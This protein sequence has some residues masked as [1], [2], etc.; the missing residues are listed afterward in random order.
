MEQPMKNCFVWISAVIASASACAFAAAPQQGYPNRPVRV[1]VFVPAGGG[2]DLLARITGLKLGEALGQTIVVDNRAGMGGVIATSLVAKA[3]PDGY[4][5]LQ[6]GI[7]THGIGPHIYGNLPYDP[8]K[9]FAPIVLTA[10]LPIF[11]VAN[12]QLPV[13]SV[14]ELIALAKAKPDSLS[15][16]SPGTGSAPHLVGELFKIVTGIPSV[17]VPYQGSGTAAPDLAAGHVQFMFDAIAGHQP[18]IQSGRV[19]ALAVTSAAR[20]AAFPDVPTMKELGYPRVDGTVWYGLMAPAAT[21]KSVIAKLNAESRRVL[22]MQDVKEKLTRA[23][24][25][26]A[27]GTPEEFGAFIRAE[28]DKWGPVVRAAGVKAN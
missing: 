27:G 7:T 28:F 13:K 5:L 9:D 4:T 2:A 1:V 18:F 25:D 3:A 24:I 20:L 17:H 22:A 11:L 26:A 23:G 16:A 6:G 8:M 15:F 19:R 21:P 12:T 10:T 14:S